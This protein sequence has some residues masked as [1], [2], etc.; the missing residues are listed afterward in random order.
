MM[1][2]KHSDAVLE[3]PY[4]RRLQVNRCE[5]V[6]LRRVDQSLYSGIPIFQTNRCQLRKQVKA[7][8]VECYRYYRYSWLREKR[9]VLMYSRPSCRTK[10]SKSPNKKVRVPIPD[11]DSKA[12]PLK[13]VSLR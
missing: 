13:F 7:L 5:G 10:E 4:R 8:S 1:V 3:A 12:D 11:I 6:V 2:G 9:L